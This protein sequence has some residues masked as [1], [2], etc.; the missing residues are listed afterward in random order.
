MT[1]APPQETGSCPYETGLTPRN[2]RDPGL[3]DALVENTRGRGKF[4][5][6]RTRAYSDGTVAA[7]RRPVTL[8]MRG[9]ARPMRARPNCAV[10][11]RTPSPYVTLREKLMDDES[12]AYRVGQLTSPMR[13][14]ACRHWASI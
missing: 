9:R 5:A 6:A 11:P 7:R 13:N 12:A 10:T 4:Q 8:K 14:P 1:L 3:L 2:V